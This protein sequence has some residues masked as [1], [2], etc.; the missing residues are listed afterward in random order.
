MGAIFMEATRHKNSVCFIGG[1]LA[2][3]F[4]PWGGIPDIAY[5]VRNHREDGYESNTV[6]SALRRYH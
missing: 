5:A 2:S 4:T 1:K 3:T 6:Q